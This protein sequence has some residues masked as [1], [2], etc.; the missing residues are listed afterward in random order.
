MLNNGKVLEWTRD[1][2]HRPF[3]EVLRNQPRPSTQT[4]QAEQAESDL[5][6]IAISIGSPRCL[7][8]TRQYDDVPCVLCCRICVPVNLLVC[9]VVIFTGEFQTVVQDRVSN[10][11]QNKMKNPSSGK[12]VRFWATGLPPNGRTCYRTAATGLPPNHLPR[13][14]LENSLENAYNFF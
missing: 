2:S 11:I 1:G 6:V 5:L 7:V 4:Y 9:A 13:K 10:S 8:L 14:C 12:S 3:G